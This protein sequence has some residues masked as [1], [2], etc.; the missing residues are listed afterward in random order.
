MIMSKTHFAIDETR[1]F[2]SSPEG[3]S[4]NA[5]DISFF[6]VCPP[7]FNASQL[8]LQA[9]ELLGHSGTAH[10]PTSFSLTVHFL[11]KNVR[12]RVFFA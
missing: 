6:H 7:L 2:G 5:F 4:R 12:R 3:V 10:P 1:N 11:R 8:S 9:Q